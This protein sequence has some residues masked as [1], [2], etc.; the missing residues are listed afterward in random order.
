MQTYYR[1]TPVQIAQLHNRLMTNTAPQQDTVYLIGSDNTKHAILKEHAME[2]STLKSILDGDFGDSNDSIEL[3][4]MRGEVIDKI[5]EYL[6]FKYKKLHP[7]AEDNDDADDMD[8]DGFANFH[9]PTELSL[10]VL[11]AADY[12]DI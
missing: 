5:V 3:P 1:P 12:L 11:L 8:E 7:D 9:I 10:D 6:D 4:S 2:S